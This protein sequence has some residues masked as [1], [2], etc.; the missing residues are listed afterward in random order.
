MGNMHE[1]PLWIIEQGG[2]TMPN[3]L[4]VSRH[5]GHPLWSK[6]A[7]TSRD[8]VTRRRTVVEQPVH[9]ANARSQ[10]E[11]A[12]EPLTAE[13]DGFRANQAYGAVPVG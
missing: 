9:T 11:I 2:E 3:T 8:R 1:I 7:E 12:I 6:R 10:I 4:L 5:L 13:L